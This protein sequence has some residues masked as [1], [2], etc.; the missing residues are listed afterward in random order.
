MKS[1]LLFLALMAPLALRANVAQPGLYRAGGGTT[2]EPAFPEDSVAFR[3]VQMIKERVFVQLYPGFAVVKG[4]YWLM[5]TASRSVDMK[6]GYPLRSTQN[7]EIGGRRLDFET[8]APV[9]FRVR[10]DGQQAAVQQDAPSG[11]E[12][13]SVRFPAGDTVQI[14]VFFITN[15][16]EASV[17]DGYKHQSAN[18]FLYLLESGIS[19]KQPI[20]DG[21][22]TLQLMGGLGLKNVKGLWRDTLYRADAARK[23]LVRSF[24]DLSPTPADN[25]IVT[26]GKPLP[27]FD[28]EASRRDT[29]T[30][31]QRIEAFSVSAP[32]AGPFVARRFDD[33]FEVGGIDWVPLVVLLSLFAPA[34]LLGLVIFL[35]ARWLRRRRGSKI[36]PLR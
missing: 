21:Q 4:T 19:W 18:G 23:I 28:F 27:N 9:E 20:R 36:N 2:F 12:I 34:L 33:P 17:L 14:D 11:W 16:N 1:L 35:L 15:T 5:N 8:G 7:T 31:Y 22:I 13:W 32:D 30:L 24:H 25:V 29:A 26:Y 6:V 10:I 3:Q